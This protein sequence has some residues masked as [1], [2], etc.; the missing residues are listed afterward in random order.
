MWKE[1]KHLHKINKHMRKKNKNISFSWQYT[2][3]IIATILLALSY[4]NKDF[5]NKY[6]LSTIF[7]LG[8]LWLILNIIEHLYSGFIVRRDGKKIYRYKNPI[9]YYSMILI[10]FFVVILLLYLIIKILLGCKTL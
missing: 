9:E 5:Q 8:A 2:P 1:D 6:V 7:T 4:F 10:L 3:I